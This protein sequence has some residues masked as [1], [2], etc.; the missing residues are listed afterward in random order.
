MLISLPWDAGGGA[1][2][3]E[4]FRVQTRVICGSERW[5]ILALHAFYDPFSLS[6]SDL[7]DLWTTY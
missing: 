1:V 3:G 6:S 7:E 4:V 2:P 5:S